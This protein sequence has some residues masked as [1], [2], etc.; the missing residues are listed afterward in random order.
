M[1]N[2]DTNQFFTSEAGMEG[3]PDKV[4]D[5]IADAILDA[6][7]LQDP[8]ARVGCQVMLANKTVLIGGQIT[9]SGF[10]DLEDVV[11]NVIKDI[12]AGTRLHEIVSV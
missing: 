12:G 11:R 8:F 6:Y 9:S 4:A 1:N 7:L 5:Q 10:V 2:S 3:H